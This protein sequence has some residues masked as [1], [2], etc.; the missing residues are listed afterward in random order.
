MIGAILAGMF[1]LLLGSFLNVCIF[2]LPRDL[3]VVRPR[4]FCPACEQT[5]AWYDN[6]P[7]LSYLLLSGRCR[8]CSS[9][10]SLR[11]PVVELLTGLAFFGA[12]YLHGLSPAAL[13]LAMFAAILITLIFSDFEERILPDE[14][15]I[16]GTIAGFVLAIFVRSP[17]MDLFP[18]RTHNQRLVSLTESVFSAVFC[19][20]LMWLVGA[21]YARVRHKE[22]LGFGDIKMIGMIGAFLGL[23]GAFLTLFMGSLVGSILG[24]LYIWLTRKEMS[25]YELPFGSFLGAGALVVAFTPRLL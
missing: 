21:V 16:G 10:I 20:A 8:K 18:F 25:S 1:G 3:S 12:V 4:S 13:K 23:R 19:S 14:F 9:R 17:L 7:I 15:T 6:I 11:Y 2:R 24:L 22:G 5:I